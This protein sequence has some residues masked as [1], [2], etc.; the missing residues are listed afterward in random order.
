M[1]PDKIQQRCLETWYDE[2]HELHDD[3]LHPIIGLG[4]EAG[5]LLNLIKK[6]LFKSGCSISFDEY[7][8]ELGDVLYYVS[9]V[10]YQLGV[11]LEELSLMNYA[12]LTEREANGVGYNKGG[13]PTDEKQRQK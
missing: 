8:D 7:L 12:K 4:G 5:E 6:D 10:A 11:T 9:I 3:L 2:S 1:K 13:P